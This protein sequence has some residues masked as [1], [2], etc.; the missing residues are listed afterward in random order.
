MWHPDYKNTTE[1]IKTGHRSDILRLMNWKELA[2]H[3]SMEKERTAR[4]G[5]QQQNI[6]NYL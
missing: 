4:K 2:E 5:G 6:N 1:P 3:D